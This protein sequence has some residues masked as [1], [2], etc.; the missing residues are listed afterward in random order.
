[1]N[2]RKN[3]LHKNLMVIQ[4]LCVVHAYTLVLLCWNLPKQNGHKTLFRSFHD[5]K[6]LLLQYYALNSRPTIIFEKKIQ[7]R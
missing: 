2:I 4:W 7:K 3:K 1:M 6:F 5:Q